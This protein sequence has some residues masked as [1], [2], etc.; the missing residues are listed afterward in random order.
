MSSPYAY[1]Y[2]PPYVFVRFLF[3]VF[4][5][6]SGLYAPARLKADPAFL[7]SAR[8]RRC[9]VDFVHPTG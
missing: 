9:V 7:R 2:A 1:R 3:F 6:L 5:F 4:K 8:S